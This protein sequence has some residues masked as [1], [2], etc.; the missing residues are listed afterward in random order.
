MIRGPL[1]FIVCDT[2]LELSESFFS[3]EVKGEGLLTKGPTCHWAQNVDTWEAP[4]KHYTGHRE[5]VE[6]KGVPVVYF[7]VDVKTLCKIF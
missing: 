1:K 7:D 2:I 5:G 3:T 4:Y 6:E